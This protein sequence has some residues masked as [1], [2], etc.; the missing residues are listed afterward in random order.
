MKRYRLSRLDIETLTKSGLR[1]REGPAP[2]L[3]AVLLT[4]SPIDEITDG[5][6]MLAKAPEAGRA[7]LEI[8]PDLRSFVIDDYVI[9]YHKLK[10]GGIGISRVIHGKR[11]RKEG[12][13]RTTKE[14]RLTWVAVEKAQALTRQARFVEKPPPRRGRIGTGETERPRRSPH[15]HAV[16]DLSATMTAPG[17]VW[18]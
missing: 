13:F 7:R 17:E 1:S 12:S 9:Y 10:R 16:G 5:F 3:Q 18:S 8:E 6:P 14:K 4:R 11:D 2:A 15:P